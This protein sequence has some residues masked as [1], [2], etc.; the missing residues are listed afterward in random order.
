[1]IEYTRQSDNVLVLKYVSIMNLNT[2]LALQRLRFGVGVNSCSM[3][4][5]CSED[6]RMFGF[7]PPPMINH[8]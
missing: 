3:K 7:P 6:V 8:L 2:L 1:M 4:D 5:V